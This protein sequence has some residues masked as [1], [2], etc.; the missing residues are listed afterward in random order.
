MTQITFPKLLAS[1]I[2]FDIARTILDGF[3]KHYSLFRAT[4]RQAKI[5]FELGEWKAAQ[6]TALERISFYAKRVTECVTILENKY[7]QS[8]LTDSVWREIKL[9]YIGLLI[10]HM[11][12]ECGESIS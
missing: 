6:K 2:A 10:D 9:H 8:E 7:D 4:S 1:Q 12:P 11:Q 3:N 5:H